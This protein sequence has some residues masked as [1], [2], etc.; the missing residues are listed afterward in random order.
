MGR[1]GI[2]LIP[3]SGVAP[4]P[5]GLIW[6]TAHENARIRALAK[7]AAELHR[8]PPA[9]V[10]SGGHRRV[11]R[12][13]G[14]PTARARVEL[15]EL[16]AFLSVAEELH[17]GRAAERMGVTPSRVSQLIR[18]LEH[19]VGRGLFDRTSRRVRLT[20]AGARLREEI[21]PPVRELER[22]FAAA[23]ESATGV[24]GTLRIGMHSP[25]NGGPHMVRIVEVFEARHPACR[26]SIVDIGFVRDQLE[27]LRNGEID[28]LATRLPI[29]RDDVTIGPVLSR[30][31]RLLAVSSQ[32]PLA[33][34]ESIGLE[35]I[36]P[37]PVPDASGL[38]REM[39]EAFIPA[40]APSGRPIRRVNVSAMLEVIMRIALGELVHPTV[41]SFLDHF[42][43]PNVVG[44]PIR[45][46]P[47][48]ETALVW[49]TANRSLKLKA[50][51]RAARDVLAQT[52]LAPRHRPRLEAVA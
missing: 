38:P 6:C 8:Q 51:E 40:R 10:G 36:A 12:S 29:S 26:V 1:D 44:V 24:A 46:L 32:H 15:P 39:I 37:Y 23:R 41:P 48:S 33:R 18:K 11:E 2:V 7:V 34:L 16:G 52:E 20:P 25:V 43:H 9:A 3:L 42:Q 30:E 45:D 22:A 5:L 31:D 35:D 21:G 49:L 17:F 50:F 4:L 27:T 13:G 19:G 47:A 14:R 28:L